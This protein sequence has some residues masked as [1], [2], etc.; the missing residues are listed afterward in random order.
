M[1]ETEP[2]AVTNIDENGVATVRLQHG[3]VNA[4]SAATLA[5][6]A[7][8][9]T[10]L[11]TADIG[12]AVLTGGP[13]LFAAGADLTEFGG[14]TDGEFR[15]VDGERA[16]QTADSF[17]AAAAAIEAMPCPTIAAISGYALGG[18]C[19]LAL[20]CDM[21]IGSTRAVLG[22][23]EIL[24]GIIPGGGGTQR[25][26]RLIGA[27]RAL[28]L[29]ITGRQ[30]KADEALTIGLLN[31]VFDAD[32]FE[33]EVDT[34]ATSL[35]TGPR[36]AIALSKQAINDGLKG[37]LQEGL[38]IE[39]AAFSAVFGTEDAAIGVQSFLEHGPGKATFTGR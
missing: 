3:K 16:G 8:E 2:L 7:D 28:D 10:K 39:R 19:E 18:G 20:A 35:A 9:F 5:A 33:V 14:T 1:S 22:Q 21:R 29:I 32:T 4:L 31:M 34:F 27:S 6:V 30:V 17:G 13:K 38:G 12:C 25:L 15:L 23:P 24:L 26:A 36:R 11:R 37:T